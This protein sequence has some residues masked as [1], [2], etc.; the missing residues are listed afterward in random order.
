MIGYKVLR[1]AKNHYISAVPSTST[2][3]YKKRGLTFPLKDCGP[4][5]VFAK[6]QSAIGFY[7]LM[8]NPATDRF[9]IFKVEYEPSKFKSVWK[10][11]GDK[12]YT[13]SK[14]KMCKINNDDFE[15]FH[16]IDS[17]IRF[18]SS[19]KLLSKIIVEA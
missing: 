19:V 9:V 10:F 18:A 3:I 14:T 6:E 1:V 8:S 16:I 5:T 7:K 11:I 17:D 4:L 13:L 15:R 2:V 12:L